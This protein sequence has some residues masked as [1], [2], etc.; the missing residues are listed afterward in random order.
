MSA[1][2]NVSRANSAR[3]W[4]ACALL[5]SG[6]SSAQIQAVCRWQTEDSLRVYARLN[7]QNYHALLQRAA[8]ADVASVSVASLP[9]LSSEL[10]IRQLL[11][12]SL[13]DAVGAAAA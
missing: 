13:T 8:R 7:P 5:A 3:I 6:A 4:L 11:G 2:S 1:W 10:V 12:M 9:A